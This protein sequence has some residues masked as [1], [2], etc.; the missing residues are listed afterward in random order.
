MKYPISP[1]FIKEEVE[2]RIGNSLDKVI[3]GEEIDHLVETFIILIENMEEVEVI[4]GE[5]IFEAGFV[6]VLEEMIV[7]IEKIEGHGGSQD[8]EK[9]EGEPGQNQ[10]LD[11][12]QELA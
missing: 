4:Y 9:G 7:E 11:P 10:V 12:V 8:Q 5:V 1:R 6:I 2:D 3:I